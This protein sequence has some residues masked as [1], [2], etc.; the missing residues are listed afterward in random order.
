M[1]ATN[2]E[3]PDRQHP[4]APFNMMRV[5]M[6]PPFRRR[7]KGR[8]WEGVNPEPICMDAMRI[9]ARRLRNNATDAERRL[10]QHLRLRQLE[11]HRFRRQV[12]ISGYIVDFACPEAKLIIELDGGQHLE[13]AA[14]DERRTQSL[15]GL[16]YRVL[17]YWND[18][19]LLRTDDVLEDILRALGRARTDGKVK[20]TPPRSSPSP[21]AKGRRH[22]NSNS[23]SNSNST[24]NSNSNSEAGES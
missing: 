1:V 8:G 14:Y 2:S 3:F 9:R 13:H 21:A 6:P 12:P 11:G 17:R 16:G 7:R 23:N 5:G 4:E 22:G 19:V 15:R 24:S 10:W 18:E 20:S